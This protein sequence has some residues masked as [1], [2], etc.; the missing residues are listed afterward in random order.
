MKTRYIARGQHLLRADRE[1]TSPVNAKLADRIV[2]IA[3]D[4]AAAT[5]VTVLSDYHKGLLTGGSRHG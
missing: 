1:Q 4:A 3:R 2:T 5:T